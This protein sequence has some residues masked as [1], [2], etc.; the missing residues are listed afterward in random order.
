M[1][2][3]DVLAFIEVIK[4]GAIATQT[5]YGVFASVPIAQAIIESTYGTSP[6]ARTDNNL[7][8]VKIDGA[9]AP[10]L[11]ITQGSWATDG[12]GGYYCHYVSWADSLEDHGYFLRNNSKSK[13]EQQ[14]ETMSQ[15][16]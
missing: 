10:D 1:A 14:Q 15:K 7:F 16:I 3:S 6:L 8:G 13:K 9:H 4:E 2:D 12:A 5:K 11:N